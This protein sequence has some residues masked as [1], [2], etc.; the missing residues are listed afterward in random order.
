M[1]EQSIF[2]ITDDS[3]YA[4]WIEEFDTMK[5][6]DVELLEQKI[7][8]LP[9]K[10]HIAI[11]PLAV[12]GSP[13]DESLAFARRFESQ[14]YRNW[15]VYV[16]PDF[17]RADR[18]IARTAATLSAA[19]IIA[20]AETADFVL[21]LPFD[22]VLPRHALAEFVLALAEVS[23]ADILYA[24]EDVLRDGRRSQPQF[25][26]D[27]DPFLIL[28]SNYI[29]S[30]T[31]FRSDAIRRAGLRDLTSTSVDNLLHA[32]T[33]HVSEVT[34]KRQILH[35][36][37]V[38]CHCTQAS[39]WSGAEARRIVS[40]HLA[41][42]GS[43]IAEI[44]S[45]PLAPQWN[46]V[47]FH[48]PKPPPLVSII[49]P[50]RD[51]A[52]LIGPCSDGILNRT[53]YS[54]L[55]LI[56]VDNGSI[57]PDALAVLDSL[58]SDPRVQVL[59]D[60]RP[61]NYSQLNNSAAEIAKGDIL[62]LMNNDIEILHADWLTELVSLA[63]R[64]DIGVVGAKLL[65][66]DLRVQHAGVVFG[67]DKAIR[68]QMRFA[69]RHETGPRGELALLR[70]VSAVTGACIALRRSLYFDVG[71]LNEKH[72]KVAYNDIDLCRRVAKKGLAIVWTP[73]AELMHHECASRGLPITPEE[74]DREAAEMIAFWS[75]N[76]EFY[77]A[78]DPF[79]NP[80]IE[81]NLECVDFARPPRLHRFRRQPRLLDHLPEDPDDRNE[82]QD[83]DQGPDVRH[84]KQIDDGVRQP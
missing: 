36:P 82:A 34:S 59:R 47:R 14:L 2:R 63:S 10:P 6:E 66:P 65:Y 21:P 75:M 62:V 3:I 43:D 29:G 50:T 80:Q 74:L 44:S 60:E 45:A 11:V 26:T 73:F 22:A 8:D 24:D 55:E 54:S 69:K 83:E 37:S 64:P 15:R 5:S 35:I 79:H 1:A 78:P 42:P 28:G 30:P 77:E 56:V 18:P 25:K 61:F 53:D 17:D 27:W 20:A 70:S 9:L 67:P 71:G 38:L 23:D 52:D 13:Q 7:K 16:S 41:K 4:E 48:L 76:P 31:L 72:L 49:V 33:L 19:L 58:K 32:V 40:A 46:R 39:D 57:A 84:G 12:G 51:R 68:H 81:F